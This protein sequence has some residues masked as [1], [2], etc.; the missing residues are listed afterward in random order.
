MPVVE[1]EDT[2]SDEEVEPTGAK[3]TPDVSSLAKAR[4]VV[5]GEESETEDED[6]EDAS[7]LVEPMTVEEDQKST[8]LIGVD[9]RDKLKELTKRQPSGGASKR[10]T[11]R[12]PKYE[13][14]LHRKL[15]EDLTLVRK[16]LNSQICGLYRS[17]TK[18]MQQQR[19]HLRTVHS[20]VEDAGNNFR[21][22]QDDLRMI[23][24]SLNLAFS[25]NYLPNLTLPRGAA[26]REATP[27]SPSLPSSS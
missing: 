2:E 26:S 5:S 9:I 22:A 4:T 7:S 25:G 11:K 1:G 18:D 12:D 6:E 19:N 10:R 16:D 3:E 17:L 24:E 13:T 27:A 14:L 21:S 20:F 23:E 15:R 8:K